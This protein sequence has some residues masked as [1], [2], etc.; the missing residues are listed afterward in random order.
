MVSS[1]HLVISTMLDCS[2]NNEYRTIP[3]SNG[4]IFST[5]PLREKN[6]D[7]CNIRS[8]V[9]FV[10]G[11]DA[12]IN[13]KFIAYW[14][15][16]RE[17]KQNIIHQNNIQENAKRTQHTYIVGDKVMMKRHNQ[18]QYGGPRYEGPYAIVTVNVNGTVRIKRR[19]F[20]DTMNIRNLKPYFD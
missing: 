9:Q 2:E 18:T 8:I 3:R 10:F 4:R 14:D 15:Y 12:V 11:R 7:S 13:T 5:V 17:R 16:I 19:K 20:Y 1:M 6:S